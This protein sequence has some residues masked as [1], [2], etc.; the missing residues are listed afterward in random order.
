MRNLYAQ[1]QI[2]IE[3]HPFE[4]SKKTK[5]I[6]CFLLPIHFPNPCGIPHLRIPL[7]SLNQYCDM[8]RAIFLDRVEDLGRSTLVLYRKRKKQERNGCWMR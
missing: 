1:L 4:V 3:N 7:P 6:H 2:V 8:T 5:K